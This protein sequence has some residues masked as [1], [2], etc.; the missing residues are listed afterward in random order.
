MGGEN[1]DV[2]HAIGFVNAVRYVS[3]DDDELFYKILFVVKRETGWKFV[4]LRIAR[5]RRCRQTSCWGRGAGSG[6]IW[7]RTVLSGNELGRVYCRGPSDDIFIYYV[8]PLLLFCVSYLRYK[9]LLSMLIGRDQLWLESDAGSVSDG[10]GLDRYRPVS[11]TSG[12]G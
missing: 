5:V 6:L 2:Y 9:L 7:D 12:I 3:Q 1:Q 10:I 4:N 11:T 8:R